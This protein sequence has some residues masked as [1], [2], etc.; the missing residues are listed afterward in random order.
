M[1]ENNSFQER[2]KLKADN[3]VRLAYLISKDF[4]RDE[5]FGIT[6][7]LRRASL[8]VVL[9][10]IEGYARQRDKVYKNFLEISY[11]SLK[12]AEYL[13]KFANRENYVKDAINYNLAISLAD[14]IGAMLWGTIDNIKY[15]I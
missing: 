14:E 2:L 12:E 15:K 6:S 1:D 3:F 5:I 9:N 8:S 7:Q 4:P 13:L 10:L 11:G